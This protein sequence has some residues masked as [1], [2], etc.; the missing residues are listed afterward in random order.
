MCETIHD[1][2]HPPILPLFTV[3]ILSIEPV[4]THTFLQLLLCVTE[5]PF[6]A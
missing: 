3:F 4:H 6:P 2:R 5:A 1:S